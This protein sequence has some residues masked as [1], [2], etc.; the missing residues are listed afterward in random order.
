LGVCW[1][2]CMVTFFFKSVGGNFL[3]EN[4]FTHLRNW[5]K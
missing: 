3:V 2:N 5:L 1:T 4:I